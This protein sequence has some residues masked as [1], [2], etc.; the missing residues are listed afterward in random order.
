SLGKK[1]RQKWN[2]FLD[3]MGPIGTAARFMGAVGG[4]AV[5]AIKGT[6]YADDVKGIFKTL[7]GGAKAVGSG[8]W[9]DSDVTNARNAIVRGAKN[10]AHRADVGAGKLIDNVAD[11]A[12]SAS[13]M[14]RTSDG[15]AELAQKAKEGVA[16]AGLK[17][18]MLPA[19]LQAKYTKSHPKKVVQDTTLEE[20]TAPT[21]TLYPGVTGETDYNAQILSSLGELGMNFDLSSPE[22]LVLGHK[23]EMQGPVPLRP[24]DPDS[25]RDG[26]TAYRRTKRAQGLWDAQYGENGTFWRPGMEADEKFQY[27][28]RLIK[29]AQLDNIMDDIG[30]HF[31]DY[32]EPVE[33]TD[34][35]VPETP[36]RNRNAD[37]HGQR[38]RHDTFTQKLKKVGKFA[39]DKYSIAASEERIAQALMG[40]GLDSEQAHDLEAIVKDRVQKKIKGKINSTIDDVAGFKAPHSKEEA[41]SFFSRVKDTYNDIF[42]YT[43]RFDTDSDIFEE[44][45]S[46]DEDNEADIDEPTVHEVPNVNNPESGGKIPTQH[47]PSVPKG[48]KSPNPKGSF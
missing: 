47:N 11:A 23:T 46:A 17:A 42:H 12:G 20:V 2:D 45:R 4:S 25:K 14:V 1:I 40:F 35:I 31:Q 26:K 9:N 13:R 21:L 29:R 16:G 37:L 36:D 34:E 15:R 22:E 24:A 32:E 18:A 7:G 28:Q 39:K 48:S 10:T 8:I 43:E 5:D 19:M 30:S 27:D 3:F 33:T 41:K 6:S 44:R 38:A